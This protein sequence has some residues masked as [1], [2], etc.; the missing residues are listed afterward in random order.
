MDIK[1]FNYIPLNVKKIYEDLKMF[2][3]KLKEF[4]RRHS[5]YILDEFIEYSSR[6]D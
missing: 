1:L 6:K 3:L 4:L 5:F 2:K